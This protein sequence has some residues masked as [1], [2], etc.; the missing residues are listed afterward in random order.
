MAVF[1][2][3]ACPACGTRVEVD[4]KMLL[5]G[6][7]FE[8]SVQACKTRINLHHTEHGEIERALKDNAKFGSDVIA[9]MRT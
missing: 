1:S 2:Q 6:Q 3:V 9:P 5:L 4:T 8:C 7:S